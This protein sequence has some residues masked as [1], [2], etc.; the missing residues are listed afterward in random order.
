MDKRSNIYTNGSYLERSPTWHVEDSPW[1]AQQIKK[2]MDKNKLNPNTVCEVGCGAGEIL[3]QLYQIYSSEIAY[4]G[5]EISPQAYELCKKRE[6]GKI[7]YCLGDFCEVNDMYFDVILLIDV[8]EHIE[9]M[10]SFLDKIKNKGEYKIFHIPLDMYALNVV[11]GDY[12]STGIAH[13]GHIHFFT[14]D[15]ALEIL[16]M[17]G[18]EILDYMY[19]PG[20]EVGNRTTILGK[21]MR[22]PQKFVYNLNSDLGIRIFG[23]VSLLVLTK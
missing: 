16:R 15:V 21:I 6:N 13:P 11:K 4:Y 17:K 19:T 12:L 5:F 23:G 8:I 14:R 3:N 10:F 20:F 9:D 7:K 1:K 2:I 22:I 18:Y